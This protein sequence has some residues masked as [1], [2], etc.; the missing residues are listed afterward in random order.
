MTVHSQIGKGQA[1]VTPTQLDVCFTLDV[2]GS[3]GKYIKTARNNIRTVMSQLQQ[4]HGFDVRFG[5]VVYRDHPPQ[6]MSFVSM[7]FPFTAE[8]EVMEMQLQDLVGTGGGDGPEAVEAGLL[9]T[10][11]L[12]WRPNATKV[13]VLIADAPP[14]GLGERDDGFPNGAPTG[15][16]PLDVLDKMGAR[17]IAVYSLGVKAHLGCYNFATAFYEAASQKTNGQAFWL[18]DAQNLATVLVGGATEEAALDA[19]QVE[20]VMQIKAI[21][22]KNP[23]MSEDEVKGQVYRSLSASAPPI[24]SLATS[25]PIVSADTPS[26]RASGSLEEARKTL[27]KVEVPVG[28]PMAVRRS[29]GASRD[30]DE[31]PVPRSCSALSGMGGAAPSRSFRSLA[32]T[33]VR[34][35]ELA[36]EPSMSRYRSLAAADDVEVPSWSGP[37]PPAEPEDE[38]SVS[39]VEKSL[40]LAQFERLLGKAKAMG[41][42]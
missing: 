18:G 16:D 17:G 9:D 14:H 13:C 34:H 41:A 7:S 15:V 27:R 25:Q 35:D 4:T 29:L 28:T 20:L 3:M 8:A 33:G 19:L 42:L 39:I 22:L 31:A 36:D 26:F 2:T 12:D 11:N 30:Y 5:L 10:L 1:G 23:D 6:D 40:T 38:A 21:K 24:T 37:Q 32:A